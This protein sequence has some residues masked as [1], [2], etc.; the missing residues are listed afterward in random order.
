M[1]SYKKLQ[2]VMTISIS[3]NVNGILGKCV[4][5][6]LW[7]YIDG[8]LTASSSN[9]DFIPSSYIIFVNNKSATTSQNWVVA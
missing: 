5:G 3:G 6:I 2:Q 1:I 8:L 7:S 9:T 4:F